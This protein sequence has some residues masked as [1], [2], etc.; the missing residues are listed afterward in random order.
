MYYLLLLFVLSVAGCTPAEKKQTKHNLK[1]EY[2]YRLQNEYF[3][4]P[5]SPQAKS[6]ESYPWENNSIGGFPRITKEFFHC[7]GNSLNQVAIQN[8]DGK[9]SLYYRDCHGGKKHGLPLVNGQEF[10]YPCLIELLNYIQHKTQ[11]RVVVTCGHRC[12]QHNSYSD[13]SAYNY[14]SKHMLGAEVDFYVEGME[15]DPLPIL[16][17]VERYYRET[18]P[19][20]EQSAYTTFERFEKGNLNIRTPAWYNKEVFVKLYLEDEGRDFDN[21]HPYPYLG[22]QVRYDRALDKQVVFDKE[23]SEN[24]LRH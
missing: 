6:R 21:Q 18:T 2:I 1:G 12:P 8:R 5:P 7:K 19:F 13:P 16:E 4:V 10:V 14:N 3:F 17:L 23:R 22:I 15:S 11:K 9:P 24:Y 20:S